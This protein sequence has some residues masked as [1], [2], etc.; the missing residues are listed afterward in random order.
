MSNRIKIRE[1]ILV[2]QLNGD[3][4]SKGQFANDL[5]PSENSTTSYARFNKYETGK[6]FRVDRETVYRIC[7]ELGCTP[8]YLFGHEETQ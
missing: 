2:A 6:S 4:R 7:S 1:A 5:F 3:K 8:D